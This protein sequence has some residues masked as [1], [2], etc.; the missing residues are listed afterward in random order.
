MTTETDE[1]SADEI[2]AAPELGRADR[3]LHP[4][5]AR[6]MRIHVTEEARHLSLRPTGCSGVCC[7]WTAGP[8]RDS[9]DVR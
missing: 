2:A 3:E 5:L 8:G 1:R 9:W 6:I 4:L 7:G